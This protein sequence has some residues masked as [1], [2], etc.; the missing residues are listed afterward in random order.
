M[1]ETYTKYMI[2][3]KSSTAINVGEKCKITNFT[4]GNTITGEFRT[5]NECVLNPANSNREWSIGD[6][7]MV[8]IKGE[9]VGSKQITLTRGGVHTTVTTATEDIIAVDL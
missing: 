8:E 1:P 4:A 9:L 5:G 2:G 6:I 7:L 3:I